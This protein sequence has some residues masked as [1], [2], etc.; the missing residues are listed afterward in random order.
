LKFLLKALPAQKPLKN[1]NESFKTKF[2]SAIDLTACVSLLVSLLH[3][4]Q[5]HYELSPN[6]LHRCQQKI[7]LKFVEHHAPA[8]SSLELLP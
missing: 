2:F 6:S 1:N 5:L 7:P 8:S 3:A 4:P